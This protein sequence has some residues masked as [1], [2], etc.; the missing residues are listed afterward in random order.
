MTTSEMEKPLKRQHGNLS[1]PSDTTATET[2]KEQLDSSWSRLIRRRKFLQGLGAA[3]VAGAAL[4]A[5]TLFAQSKEK[6]SKND[7]KLLQLALTIELIE[8]DLWQ[9][10]NELGGAV[11]HNDQPNP[12]NPA[13]VA[14][15]QNL[16][17]DMPQ[18][19][20][21]NTDDEIS[22][23]AFLAAYL[24]SKGEVP[25]DLKPF[26]NL[27]GSQA[28]GA[29]KGAGRITNLLSLNVDT[30]WYF[31]YRSTQNPDLGATF[32]Q[33]LN[34]TNQ[35]AIPLN[36]TDTPPGTPTNLFQPPI[37]DPKALRMQAI[38]NTAGFHF[39]FIEQGGSSLYPILALKAT[40]REV[41]RIL[42][43][44]GGVEIDHFSLWHDKGG[45]AIA[46]PL[47]GP[48][49]LTDPETGLTF[50]DFNNPVNQHNAQLSAKDQAAG[51]QMFQTN[52]ILPEPC[53][54]LSPDLPPVS[55]IRPT[56]TQNGGAVATIQS[57]TADNLFL[58]QSKAFFD[59]VMEVAMAADAVTE[60][61]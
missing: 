60:G 23:A 28:T 25:V 44:I 58:H 51:S 16:D 43:S 48:N 17:G 10:Y 32:P 3:G 29:N 47:A 50:P 59:L 39:T 30:S 54:F 46:Q 19:I 14:A 15:L 61:N 33:L 2:S 41:L 21:D 45:N 4:P 26:A 18:Y 31:R 9:Q 24:T 55:I 7:V 22:H 12:G 57:F 20:S 38:A 37:T 1:V 36:D 56:L 27:Q 53:E 8:A 6:L 13:Y 49:G 42:L 35:P 11:D 52:L 40:S 5:T 34:I